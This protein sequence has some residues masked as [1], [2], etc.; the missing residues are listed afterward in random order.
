MALFAS[1]ICAP[2]VCGQITCTTRSAASV[3]RMTLPACLPPASVR[4]LAALQSESA[5][6]RQSRCWTRAAASC[7]TGT[8]AGPDQAGLDLGGGR[9]VLCSTAFIAVRQLI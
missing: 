4:A 7:S 2:V 3:S 6:R 5:R 1:T 8:R 9:V